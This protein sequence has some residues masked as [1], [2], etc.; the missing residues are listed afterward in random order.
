E[1]KCRKSIGAAETDDLKTKMREQIE[2]TILALRLHFDPEYHLSF[3]RLDREIKNKELKSLLSFYIERAYRYEYL[4]ENAYASYHAFLQTLNTGFKLS[5][6]QLGLI[7]NFSAEKK[8]HKELIDHDLTFFTFG[9]NLI[10]QI[11]DPDSDLNTKR[12]EDQ[13]LDSELGEAVGINTKLRPFIQK[14]KSKEPKEQKDET[15]KKPQDDKPNDEEGGIE[16]VI[17]DS[18]DDTPDNPATS[19]D[20][21]A[22][23]EVSESVSEEAQSNVTPPEYD[24]LIGKNSESDQYGILG[25]S[26]H[27][28]K[29]AMDL[30]ETNT[31]SL[32][33]VQGGGK[34]YTI[35]TISEMVLKQ[36]NK[37]NKL[38]SPLAGVIFHYSE[39]MDYEPE[40]TSM[41]QPND[42]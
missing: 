13:E 1:I 34:S 9:G 3:D 17:D 37:I 15:S 12:L 6:K 42:K 20:H 18:P 25:E 5:F 26:I 2:N 4:S 21:P 30:S 14:L 22:D 40:F 29:I 23:S 28:K 36:F 7:F 31:I 24:I 39:S 10:E 19:I 32:F 41:K 11:L 38:P 8:H 35:G 27:G 33:G 16:E